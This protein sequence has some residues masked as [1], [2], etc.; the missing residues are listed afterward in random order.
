MAGFLILGAVLAYIELST[1]IALAG[2]AAMR[3]WAKRDKWGI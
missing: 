2:D 1:L 3:W